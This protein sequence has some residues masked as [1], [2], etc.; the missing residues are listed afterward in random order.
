MMRPLEESAVL[1]RKYELLRLAGFGGMAQLWVAKNRAT[2][3]EVC[4]KVLV[5]E[6]TDDEVVERFRREAHAAA[7]L[8]HRAIIRIFD[9]VE[10]DATYE[11]TTERP[12]AL[13]IVMELLRGETLGDF[14]MKRGALAVEEA[15]DIAL[16][17]VSG[18][19]HAHRAGVVH[20]DLKP[21][22]IFLAVEPDG[23]V[24]PKILDFGVSKLESSSG[25]V[26]TID[27]A[28]LGTPTFMSPEQARGARGVDPRS[29]V[30]SAGILLYVML[31]GSNPFE[32][33]TFHGIVS[34]ILGDDPPRLA[35][36]PDA[37]WAVLAK[38]LAKN[39]GER[40]ADATELGVALRRA[41]GRTSI[42][43]SGPQSLGVVP[44]GV[45]KIV[46]PLG[47]DS[48]VSVPPVSGGG[49]E[50]QD[51]HD[52][53]LPRVTRPAVRRRALRIVL[54]VV[55][56]SLALTMAAL[57][58]P[59]SGSS[60][61]DAASSRASREASSAAPVTAASTATPATSAATTTA[62]P[63]VSATTVDPAASP[64][65]PEAGAG[66]APPTSDGARL[67]APKRTAEPVRTAKPPSRAA[68]G[69]VTQP[70][71]EPSIVRD[72]GF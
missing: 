37:L 65:V 29:D 38:A 7:R 22:N 31:A 63:A 24:I 69:A 2:G 18:L 68:P 62:A 20:R 58:R 6:R 26:L 41:S 16:P 71:R 59:P 9:L 13:A 21:D 25:P 51:P 56:A 28:V 40:F 36:V 48:H 67:P 49:L 66:K 5:P 43:E 30:F 3:A 42:T 44:I 1:A 61:P 12:A 54:A 50:P 19:A 27:G 53:A 52:E 35:S 39:A 64:T 45:R 32:R 8:S 72:P 14:L 4:I 55:G 34:A 70:P 15:I 11:L 46:P 57:L 17:V 23:H 60:S 10:L 47:G 33:D